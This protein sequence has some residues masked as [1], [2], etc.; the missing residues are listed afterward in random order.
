MREIPVYSW[1]LR[2]ASSVQRSLRYGPVGRV[3]RKAGAA[4]LALARLESRV[5]EK[6]GSPGNVDQCLLPLAFRGTAPVRLAVVVIRK[7]KF[8]IGG[9]LGVAFHADPAAAEA[10]GDSALCSSGK[11]IEN[12]A[13][14]FGQ[15]FD[16]EPRGCLMCRLASG[17]TDT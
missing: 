5:S 1:Q 4:R 14:R 12:Q 8:G 7:S 13:A 2:A 11:R 3:R 17:V 6:R 9:V 10:F 16:E 15:E